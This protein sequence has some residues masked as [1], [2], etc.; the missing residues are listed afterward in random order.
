MIFIFHGW[1]A[2]FKKL[3]GCG[4][5]GRLFIGLAEIM[6]PYYCGHFRLQCLILGETTA[7][8][9]QEQGEQGIVVS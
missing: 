1:L 3:E 8:Q 4:H 7:V 5:S 9:K 6:L 2:Y